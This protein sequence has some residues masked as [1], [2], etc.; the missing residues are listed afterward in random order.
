MLEQSLEN[1][2]EGTRGLRTAEI[3]KRVVGQA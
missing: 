3:E 2:C 1:P